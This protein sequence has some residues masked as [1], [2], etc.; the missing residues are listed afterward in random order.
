MRIS[1]ATLALLIVIVIVSIFVAN[2]ANLINIDRNLT[3][4]KEGQP[5]SGDPQS[6]QQQRRRRIIDATTMGTKA[7][8]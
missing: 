1:W 7:A 4:K 8:I 6:W 5:K 2:V 3:H